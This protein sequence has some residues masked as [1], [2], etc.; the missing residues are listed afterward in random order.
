MSKKQ[1]ANQ[2]SL[3]IYPKLINYANQ[4]CALFHDEGTLKSV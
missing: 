1:G 4:V 2:F 3:F